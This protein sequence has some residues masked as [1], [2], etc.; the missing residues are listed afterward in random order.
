MIAIIMIKI[1][2]INTKNNADIRCNFTHCNFMRIILYLIFVVRE[3]E[4]R[5]V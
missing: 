2:I 5:N 3:S 4:K 1:L